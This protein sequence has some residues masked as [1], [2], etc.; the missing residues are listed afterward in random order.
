MGE[1]WETFWTLL[2]FGLPMYWL[3]LWAGRRL[4]EKEQIILKPK[5]WLCPHCLEK[6]KTVVIDAPN[7]QLHYVM[8]ERHLYEFHQDLT[9]DLFET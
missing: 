1:F 9:P 3:G 2:G 8:R 5:Q 7:T 4:Y 6:N